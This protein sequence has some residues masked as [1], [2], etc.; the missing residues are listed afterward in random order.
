MYNIKHIQYIKDI[1]KY[2][3]LDTVASTMLKCSWIKL[4]DLLYFIM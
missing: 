3:N 1:F 2:N 4:I